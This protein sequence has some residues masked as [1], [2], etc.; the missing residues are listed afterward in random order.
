MFDFC[1]N[2]KIKRLWDELGDETSPHRIAWSGTRSRREE[3]VG[4]IVYRRIGESSIVMTWPGRIGEDD[5]DVWILTRSVPPF[6]KL[7][8]SVLFR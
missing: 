3:L 4:D 8:P 1:L 6:E 5:G 7:T 2:F